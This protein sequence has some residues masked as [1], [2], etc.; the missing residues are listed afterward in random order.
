MLSFERKN[1]G[2]DVESRVGRVEWRKVT[3]PIAHGNDHDE[4]EFK[5]DMTDLGGWV[6]G[7]SISLVLAMSSGDSMIP[8]TLAAETATA[9]DDIGFGDDRISRP[10]AEPADGLS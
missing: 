6:E 7:V 2:K 8:A 3:G 4:S 9:S 1:R 5:V 10:P